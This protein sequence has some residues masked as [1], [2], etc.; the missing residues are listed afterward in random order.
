[1]NTFFEYANETEMCRIP[2]KYW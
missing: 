2:E 1:M